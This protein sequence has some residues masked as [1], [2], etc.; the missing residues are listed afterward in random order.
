MLKRYISNPD[1]LKR[2][3]A[4]KEYVKNV[5]SDLIPYLTLKPYDYRPGNEMYYTYMYNILNMIKVMDIPFCGRVLEVGSGS[6]WIT[7][8]LVSLG[9]QVDAVEPCEDFIEISRKRIESLGA[10]H[11]LHGSAVFHQSALEEISLPYNSFD[12]IL[13]YDS[14]HHVIDEDACLEKCTKLLKPGAVLGIHDWAWDPQSSEQERC[15]LEDMSK[16]GTLE[17]PFT[18]EYL[19]H[20]LLKYKFINIQRYFQVNGMFTDCNMAISHV[21]RTSANEN[22]ILTAINA[23][24]CQTSIDTPVS[25]HIDI[26]ERTTV[27]NKIKIKASITNTGSSAWIHKPIPRG[28][29]TIALICDER[30]ADRRIHFPKMLLPGEHIILDLEYIIPHAGKWHL[31]LV[32]EG[33]SWFGIKDAVV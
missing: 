7:E 13:F 19:D 25:G 22:N 10:H 32:H 9:Y 29:I 28:W 2:I 6:G 31:D 24:P 15:I 3:Q 1:Y 18:A 16:Y 23:P 20:L 26:L 5:N 4:A 30:E 21:A 8:I 17:S 27:E 11:H 14:L 12:A 33:I